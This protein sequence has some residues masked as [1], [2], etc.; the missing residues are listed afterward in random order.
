M[1]CKGE[2][3]F[4]RGNFK[5]KVTDYFLLSMQRGEL[6]PGIAELDNH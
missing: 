3:R 6:K 2:L 4:A 5:S 1:Q